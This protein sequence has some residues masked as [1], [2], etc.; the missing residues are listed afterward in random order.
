MSLS[1]SREPT[2]HEPAPIQTVP[3]D[4][5]QNDVQ[6]APPASEK[7]K[8]AGSGTHES[9]Y[10]VDWDEND[11]DNPYTWSRRRKWIITAQVASGTLSV[12]F[13]S[14]AYSAGI[15]QTMADLSVSRE[16]AVLGLSL[17]V[18]L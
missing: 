15:P 13:G 14:S 1:L 2:L 6:K 7:P 3:V 4:T 11:P 5:V 18:F 17:Y 16:V 10:I 12:S 8:Y 9:P